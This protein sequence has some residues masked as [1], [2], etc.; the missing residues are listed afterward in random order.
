L[1]LVLRPSL[2]FS[3]AIFANLRCPHFLSLL[4]ITETLHNLLLE[5]SPDPSPPLD[6]DFPPDRKKIVTV[7]SNAIVSYLPP[8]ASRHERHQ[9]ALELAQAKDMAWRLPE[10][11]TMIQLEPNEFPSSPCIP[12][13]TNGKIIRCQ[14]SPSTTKFKLHFGFS[15]SVFTAFAVSSLIGIGRKNHVSLLLL[16]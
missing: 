16:L 2:P 8:F 7:Q 1:A 6:G 3:V 4:L 15:L 9:K 14:G 12:I 11:G 5:R 13:V 10:S